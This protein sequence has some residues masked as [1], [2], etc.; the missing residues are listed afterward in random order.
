MVTQLRHLTGHFNAMHADALLI[1]SDEGTSAYD[2]RTEAV[3]KTM[4]QSSYYFRIERKGFC[5][6]PLFPGH[7]GDQ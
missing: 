2:K 7:H 3:L 4:T 6:N 1:F 5:C